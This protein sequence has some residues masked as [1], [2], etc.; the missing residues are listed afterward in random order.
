MHNLKST[1]R[2]YSLE[3]Q[4]FPDQSTI[5]AIGA[6]AGGGALSSDNNTM[7]AF[8]KGLTDRV[9]GTIS[10]PVTDSN[11]NTADQLINQLKNVNTYLQSLYDFFGDQ[12]FNTFA[13][14]NYDLDKA[15]DY[16]NSLK[17]LIN[18]HKEIAI[19]KFKEGNEFPIIIGYTG[20]K[21]FLFPLMFSSNKEKDLILGFVT[22]AFIAND[23]KRYTFDMVGYSLKIDKDK[24]MDEEMKKIYAEGKTIKDHPDHVEILMCGAISQTERL[25][26][27]YEIDAETNKLV[28]MSEVGELQGRFAELLPNPDMP[29]DLIKEV[30][31]HF[32]TLPLPKNFKEEDLPNA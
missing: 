18:A 14:G 5:V 31:E 9:I 25:S 23:V 28:E 15:A 2:S 11:Q 17:D 32:K 26:V 12:S 21:R 16:K 1:V 20:T 24:N 19:D 29:K 4:I 22:L 27:S 3:S 8:N 13:D 7:A 6:Q 10:D 30:K